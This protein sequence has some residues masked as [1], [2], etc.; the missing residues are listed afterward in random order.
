MSTPG[1]DAAPTIGALQIGVLFGVCLFGAVTVQVL[2][3]YARFPHDPYALKGLV[4]LVW[5]L[6]LG[7][8][9]AISN[10]I[11]V[12]TVVQ[13]GHPELLIF[14]PNSLNFGTLLSGFIAP[15][16]QSWF[17]YR[18]YK[19][20]H[21]CYL[22]LLCVFLSALRACASI[23]LGV[24]I[25][26]HTTVSDF[27]ENWGWMIVTMLVVGVATDII[28]VLSL[29]YYLSAWRGD[30]FKRMNRLVN[31]L[32]KW[33][34]ETGLITSV[35]A[36]ALLI[37]FIRMPDNYSWIAI[38]VVLSKLFSNS[39]MFSLNSRKPELRIE[40]DLKS[41]DSFQTVHS[42]EPVNLEFKFQD[43]S[44]PASTHGWLDRQSFAAF[45]SDNSYIFPHGE[46][47][48]QLAY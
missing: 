29:C 30:G 37:C 13:Y 42:A 1:F 2:L 3:Y 28:L 24:I 34:I 21:S 19:F 6:D 14:V 18:L 33:S 35:G 12:I 40:H 38:S 5:C 43:L 36:M 16:E 45:S 41:R 7:H 22:P 27:I 26:R 48:P 9:V 17:A 4:A 32:M 10:S 31:R 44:P 8:T 23:A 47:V 46:G 15:I 25:L 39:F 11:Y 20:S